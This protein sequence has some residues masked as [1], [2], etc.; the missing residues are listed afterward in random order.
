MIHRLN[1]KRNT[2]NNLIS[3][4]I[5]NKLIQIKQST[6]CN[7]LLFIEG[8]AKKDITFAFPKEVKT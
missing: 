2:T 1:K 7:Q 8:Q 3:P 5:V 4:S 6:V